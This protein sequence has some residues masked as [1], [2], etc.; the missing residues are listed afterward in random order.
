MKRFNNILV[1]TD[2][3]LS[4][5]PI[6]EE[7]AELARMNDASLKIVDVVPEFPW[8]A[9]LMLRDHEDI[10]KVL[11]RDKQARLDELASELRSEGLDVESKVLWG[12]TSV[13]IIREVLRGQHDLVMRVARGHRSNHKGFFG[14]TGRRLLRSCPCAVWLVADADTPKY[15]NVLAC[16]DTSTGHER[17][18]ELNDRVFDLASGISEQHDASLAVIQAWSM[19]AEDILRGRVSPVYLQEMLESRR[20]YVEEQLDTFLK[21]H[22]S[23]VKAENVHL[24]KDDPALAISAFIKKHNV[25]LAVMG[26]VAR[27]GLSGMVIGNT[28]E[29]I[30]DDLECSVL[31]VK[32]DSFVS[33]IKQA[34]YIN[35]ADDLAP[36]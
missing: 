30:L 15:K 35:Y 16:V 21:S 1:A 29:R 13:E 32:P 3:R 26:T 36:L 6:V 12:R 5:H 24:I 4:S 17:D 22:G 25:D 11:G 7:A 18:N 31:A 20:D 19:E 28:A 10:R 2:M 34:E 27:S 9:R 14:A 33:P 8:A 23:S